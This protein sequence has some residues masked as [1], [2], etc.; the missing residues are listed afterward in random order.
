MRG[1]P[2]DIVEEI[3]E[4]EKGGIMLAKPVDMKMLLRVVDEAL[5][6]A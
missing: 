4:G 5:E 1:V 6:P 3:G 2:E